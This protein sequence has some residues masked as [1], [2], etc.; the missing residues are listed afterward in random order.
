MTETAKTLV[1][2]WYRTGDTT[3]L[4][5]GIVWSVLTTFPE[6]GQYVGRKT[7]EEQFFTRIMKHFSDYVTLP[8]RVTAEGKSVATTGVYRVRTTRGQSGDIAF[9]HVWTVEDGKIT[10]LHQ[11]ADTAAIQKLLG[12]GDQVL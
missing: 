1:E 9:A 6:G 10:A 8:H 3:L 4:S 11:I 12:N 5:E 7:V 2:T